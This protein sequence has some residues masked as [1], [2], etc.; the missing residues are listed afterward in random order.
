MKVW[1]VVWGEYD[2]DDFC[3]VF[4]TPELAQK[5]VDKALF[6]QQDNYRILE[7]EVDVD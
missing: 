2:A 7:W 5:C 1:V 3:G 4:S 6:H